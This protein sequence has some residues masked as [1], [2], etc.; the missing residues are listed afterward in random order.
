MQTV[1]DCI[2]RLVETHKYK[3]LPSELSIKCREFYKANIP[4]DLK[5]DGDETTLFSKEGTVISK[6]YNRIV[7]GDYGA[8]IEISQAF[9]C[10]DNLII[11]AGQEYRL[12]KPYIDNVKYIWLTAKD[13]SH[14][15][16]YEQLRGVTYAD[17]KPDMYYVSIYEVFPINFS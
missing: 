2:E 8:Y 7:I 6:G 3:K 10:K 4:S 5:L 1:I 11:E 12:R 14:V 17:Y 15:K 13:N 9:I 16:I